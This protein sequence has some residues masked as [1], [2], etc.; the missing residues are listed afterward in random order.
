[1]PTLPLLRSG[2]SVQ[3][4]FVTR[5]KCTTEIIRFIDGSEQRFTQAGATRTWKISL[6]DLMPEE[7]IALDAFA[8]SN[9]ANNDRFTFH[10]PVSGDVLNQ[11]NLATEPIEIE[12]VGEQRASLSLIVIEAV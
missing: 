10:D 11:C 1:M 9:L 8:Q 2:S 5:H 3:Y 12:H 6:S 4:P 7:V